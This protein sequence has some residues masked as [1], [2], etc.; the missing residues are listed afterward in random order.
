MKKVLVFDDEENILEICEYIL[1][2][3]G[4]EVITKQI[5]TNVIE[6]LKEVR[7]DIVLMDNWIPEIGGI[8]ATQKIKN[9]PEFKNVPVVYFSANNDV[10]K[11][12]EQAGADYFVAKPFDLN[13]LEEAVVRALDNSLLNQRNC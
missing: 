10:Q 11:L 8:E 2:M 3:K 1:T 13:V 7:P 4:F 12:A 5:C 9:H 6:D